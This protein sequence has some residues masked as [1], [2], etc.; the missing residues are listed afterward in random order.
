MSQK[1]VTLD[2]YKKMGGKNKGKS[3]LPKNLGIT[4]PRFFQNEFTWKLWKKLF[5]PTGFHLWD[6]AADTKSHNLFCDACEKS[7][8]LKK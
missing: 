7:I 2:E 6:E 1:T 4:Y 8:K 3:L 5:C